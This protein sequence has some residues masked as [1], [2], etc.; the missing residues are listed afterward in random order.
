MVPTASVFNEAPKAQPVRFEQ[1]YT[2]VKPGLSAL[3]ELMNAQVE[4]FEPEIR[5]LVEYTLENSGKRLRPMLM[6]FSGSNGTD[7]VNPDL[8]KAAAVVEMVHIATLV[9]DDI[10]DD[11]ALRHRKETVAQKFGTTVAVL[12]GDALF[13]HALKLASDFKTVRVCQVVASATQRVCSGEISQTLRRGN[14]DLSRESYFRII[15]MKTAELFQASC[16]LGAELSDGDP[17]FV[18]A[19]GTFGKHLGIAYQI[20][21]DLTDLYGEEETTGKTLGTDLASGKITLPMLAMKEEI[22]E[23][24]FNNLFIH[25]KT[26]D[27]QALAHFHRELRA[28]KVKA[29]VI[30]SFNAEIEAARNAIN[31][32]SDLSAH[33]PLFKLCDFVSQQLNSLSAR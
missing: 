2:Q 15:E 1:L 7:S 27:P 3:A 13:A 30:E 18:E 29:A 11:A 12:L 5:E 24:V 10:L 20:F 8:V 16:T 6:F 28:P 21:D 9:H 26:K 32:F 31:D 14:P 22:G 23:T 33:A 19:A 17:A 4:D 25:A